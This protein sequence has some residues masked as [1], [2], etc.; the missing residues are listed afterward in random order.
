MQRLCVNLHRLI[1]RRVADGVKTELPAVLRHI[2]G[3]RLQVRFI[4]EER[5]AVEAGIVL[6]L[7]GR[8]R[9]WTREAAVDCRRLAD[10][11]EAQPIIAVPGLVRISRER[12]RTGISD[13]DGG[14]RQIG[15]ELVVHGT[16]HLEGELRGRL[17]RPQL[18]L[19]F[20]ADRGRGDHQARDAECR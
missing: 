20:V 3:E 13:G 7:G 9:R 12:F 16:Q 5:L 17:L 14:A 11:T 18:F 10:G 1:D 4:G 19:H 6:V 8:P 15:A 2:V